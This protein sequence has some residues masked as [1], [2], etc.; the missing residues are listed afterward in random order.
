MVIMKRVLLVAA[1][2]M[3]LL[4]ASVALAGGSSL[5]S[6]YAGQ[7]GVDAQVAG[8]TAPAKGTLPFTGLDLALIVAAGAT[9]MLAGAALRRSARR[10]T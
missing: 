4:F 1:V 10:K 9:L 3:S 8:R 6:G 7:S 2:T 5:L